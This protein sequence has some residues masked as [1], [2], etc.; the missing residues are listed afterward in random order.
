MLENSAPAG[1]IAA[2]HAFKGRRFLC[3]LSSGIY[4]KSHTHA[5]NNYYLG[6]YLSERR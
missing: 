3:V 6:S 2:N 5:Y 4:A 1:S